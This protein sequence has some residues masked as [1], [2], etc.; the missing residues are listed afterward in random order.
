MSELQSPGPV[1]V[2]G[3]GILG[4]TT[5][6]R[7]REQG[8]SVEIW[9]RDD[10]TQTTSSVAAAIWYP[11]LAEPRGRVANWSAVTFAHLAELARLPAT[12]VRMQSVVEVFA[13][14]DP[15]LWWADAVP[16]LKRLS[17]DDLPEGYAAAVRAQVPLCEVPIHLQWLVA[18]LR[19]RGVSIVRRKV[20]S[21]DE[22]FAVAATVVNC[23]GLGAREL[24]GDREVYATRGQVL[25][26]QANLEE[27]WV[28]DTEG[29]PCYVIPRSDGVIVGGTAQARDERLD[30]D[31][32]DTTAILSQALRAF[33][34]LR[35][36]KVETVKVGLRPCRSTVRLEREAVS[37]GRCL[38]H[39]YGHG[40][41]GYT[42][43]WGCA[44]E[45]AALV[46]S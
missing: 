18:E 46:R 44:Q 43:A 13:E 28:D 31:D 32:A 14:P 9:T 20:T 16:G 40:G 29:R 42:L 8:H 3:A 38:V 5:A 36:A 22:A 7:L 24:C 34:V 30:I 21:F 37:N 35:D 4:L 1:V 41:S 39:N 26:M 2:L 17:G 27:A 11:F 25:R 10:P 45:V 23:T 15:D 6:W 19:E 12:G 33:P